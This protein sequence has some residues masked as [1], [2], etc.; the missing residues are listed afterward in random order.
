MKRILAVLL[1]VTMIFCCVFSAVN[2]NAAQQRKSTSYNQKT[3]L[4]N[5]DDFSWDNASVYFLLTDRFKNGNTSNDHSYGRATDS[6]GKP[7]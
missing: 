7:L 4:K 2:V 6:S 5:P 3:A 1:C